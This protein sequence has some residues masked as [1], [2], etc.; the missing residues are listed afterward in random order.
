M[1]G[2]AREDRPGTLTRPGNFLCLNISLHMVLNDRGAS[3]ALRKPCRKHQQRGTGRLSC[4]AHAAKGSDGVP[5]KAQPPK[6]SDVIS[7]HSISP[8]A[9]ATTNGRCKTLVPAPVG[10]QRTLLCRHTDLI[11]VLVMVTDTVSPG[12]RAP[13]PAPVTGRV[14]LP[15]PSVSSWTKLG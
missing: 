13:V 12:V 8:S 15:L 1:P 10:Q 9:A 14:P 2:V 4:N 11:Q 6:V 7:V 3:L 5:L